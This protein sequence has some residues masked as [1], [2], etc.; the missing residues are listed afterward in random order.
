MHIAVLHVIA[1]VLTKNGLGGIDI[2]KP[3]QKQ[4]TMTILKKVLRKICFSV[5]EVINK[6]FGVESNK[7]KF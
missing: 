3:L 4:P 6:I 5:Q 7:I 1:D 2:L